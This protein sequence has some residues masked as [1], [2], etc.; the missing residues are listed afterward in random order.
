VELQLAVHIYLQFEMQTAK[1]D[2]YIVKTFSF[3]TL[4]YMFQPL[5]PS[6][7]KYKKEGKH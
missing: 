2:A 6:L 3:Y 7:Q 4:G 5:W 1:W